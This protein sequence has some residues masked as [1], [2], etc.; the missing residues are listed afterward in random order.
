MS[1][2]DANGP[3]HSFTVQDAI[4]IATKAHAGQMDQIHVPYIEHCLA[5]M[6]MFDSDLE[7]KVAILHD[8]VEDTALSLDDLRAAGCDDQVVDAVEALTKLPGEPLE[9]SMERV[10]ENPIAANV[11]LADIAHNVSRIPQISDPA[12]RKRLTSKYGKSLSLLGLAESR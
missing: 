3:A 5:V 10:R 7:M 9:S 11:K 6:K 8:T 1:D 4:D 12:T 2:E